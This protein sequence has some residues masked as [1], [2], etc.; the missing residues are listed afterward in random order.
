MPNI[1]DRGW[2]IDA[3]G[4]LS[5]MRDTK[6]N[7]S[8]I[9][10]N[11]KFLKDR[12]KCNT[13]CG[14]CRCKCVKRD[15]L[16]GPGCSCEQCQNRTDRGTTSQIVDENVNREDKLPLDSDDGSDGEL[17]YSDRDENSDFI[18]QDESDEYNSDAD[19]YNDIDAVVHESEEVHSSL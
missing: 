15:T 18:Q 1:L 12:Y 5:V 11:I 19:I 6:E 17:D 3:T 10:D 14:N 16:C 8:Q 13:G 4:K 2:E 9:A 7:I